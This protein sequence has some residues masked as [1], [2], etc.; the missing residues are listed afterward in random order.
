M[1]GI[2]ELVFDAFRVHP[3]RRAAGGADRGGKDARLKLELG[4]FDK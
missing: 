3:L 1:R 4:E 2:H